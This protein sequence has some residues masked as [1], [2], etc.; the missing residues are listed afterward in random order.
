[1]SGSNVHDTL[2]VVILLDYMTSNAVKNIVLQ[3]DSGLVCYVSIKK[4]LNRQV[5]NKHIH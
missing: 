5:L 2:C 1:M 4:Y 3:V